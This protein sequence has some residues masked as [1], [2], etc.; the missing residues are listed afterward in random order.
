MLQ[1][2][3]TTWPP[4]RIPTFPRLRLSD[5]ILLCYFCYRIG[6]DNDWVRLGRREIQ[7]R[8]CRPGGRRVSKRIKVLHQ[9]GIL[10]RGERRAITQAYQ[11]R[12]SSKFLETPESQDW[13]ALSDALFDKRLP[14]RGLFDRPVVG[15]G[16]LNASGVLVLGAILA[17][18]SGVSTGQ[19][20]MYFRGLLGEQTVRN[21]VHRLEGLAAVT[22]NDD[23]KLVPTADWKVR[24]DDFEGAVGAKKRARRLRE[25]IQFER[26]LFFGDFE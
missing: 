6:P 23:F 5:R 10:A 17:A 14:W 4:L 3:E 7:T 24:L 1:S 13:R 25:E 9:S 8:F 11:Y 18:G 20:Q 26:E 22:R 19:L 21:S 2:H 16:F 12:L 15:H